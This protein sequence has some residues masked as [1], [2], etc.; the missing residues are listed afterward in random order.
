MASFLFGPNW[1]SLPLE[2]DAAAAASGK[3]ASAAG[4]GKGNLQNGTAHHAPGGKALLPQRPNESPP[5][6]KQLSTMKERSVSFSLERQR[7]VG[8]EGAD[9]AVPADEPGTPKDVGVDGRWHAPYLSVVPE[10]PLV[11]SSEGVANPHRLPG[12]VSLSLHGLATETEACR[13]PPGAKRQRRGSGGDLDGGAKSSV[14]E[15]ALR[16]REKAADR[17]MRAALRIPDDVYSTKGTVWGSMK[18][19]ATGAGADGDKKP[20]GEGKAGAASKVK[21]DPAAKQPP[22]PPSGSAVPRPS[23]VPNFLPPFPTDEDSDLASEKLA[24]AAST[25]AVMDDVLSRV[26]SREKRKDPPPAEGEKDAMAERD[27]V[28]RSVIGLGK[29]L[30]TSYWGALDDEGSSSGKG[31]AATRPDLSGVT[32][33]P[34]E[35]G[36][37]ASAAKKSGPDASQVVPLGR[38][39]GSR[40]S[41]ILEGSMA[42]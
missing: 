28:R 23:Y 42:G 34:G 4:E 15:M 14:V 7:S 22:V 29:P 16:R 31:N 9:P 5:K 41:K 20:S 40:L 24:A 32:V 38:A 26:H 39:S 8:G 2:G 11:S 33:A 27:S 1:V 35:R 19:E 18:D 12:K 13:D 30:G 37:G 6:G 17:A 25:T 21:F 36:S 10:F 3:E